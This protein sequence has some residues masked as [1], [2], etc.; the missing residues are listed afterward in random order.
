MAK[1]LMALVFLFS[2]LFVLA[3]TSV[4]TTV[5]SVTVPASLKYTDPSFFKK[6]LLGRNYR[7]EWSTPVTFPVFRIKQTDL[8]IEELGGGQQTKSLQLKDKLGREWVLRT[9]DKDVEKA[10]PKFLRGT[11]VQRITQ[12]MVSAAH[13]Y[14][15]LTIPPL[16]KAIGVIVPEPTFYFIPDDPALEP[17]RS[18]FANTICM[19]EQREPTPDRSETED[20][21]DL[22]KE[23]LEENEHMVI[24]QAVLRARLL[25]MIVA[26]WDRHADQWRWGKKDSGAVEYFYAIPRDRDQ[27]YFYSNGVL[28]KIARLVALR[29]LVGFQDDLDK[30]KNLNFKSWEFD[31]LFLNQLNRK[32]WESIIRSAQLSLTDEVIHSAVA[33]LPPAIYSLNGSTIE[34]KLKGRRNDLLKDGLKYYDFLFR[35]A[36]VNGTNEAEYFKI[37]GSGDSLLVQVYDQ[38]DNKQG[39]KIYE[40]VFLP[41]ETSQVTLQGYGGTDHFWVDEQARSEIRLKLIGGTGADVYDVRG[42]FKSTIYD[43]DSE[44]NKIL[45]RS[46]SRVKKDN[47]RSEKAK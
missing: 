15:P 28:L 16:A 22:M 18:A 9:V 42:S 29:H 1:A 8:T 5:D 46:G 2:S 39:R 33:K 19:L 34:A 30:L 35:Y 40:R 13:P 20:T 26:D 25:D 17:Y 23:L 45:N 38:K 31:R 6:F 14:A 37:S 44:E 43:L 21:D 7:A 10:L 36:V 27:A 41:S 11:L 4:V 24:Q 32:E 47:R 12:D 3:Q